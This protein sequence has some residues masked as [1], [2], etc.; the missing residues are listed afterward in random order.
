[1]STL[2]EFNIKAD[3][4]EEYILNSKLFTLDFDELYVKRWHLIGTKYDFTVNRVI[5]YMKWDV[6]TY[7]GYYCVK[8]E[9]VFNSV[10][11]EIQEEFIFNLDLFK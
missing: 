8:F 2:L 10:S 5:R 6:P 1:M 11:K 4:I 7:N 3:K 9:E